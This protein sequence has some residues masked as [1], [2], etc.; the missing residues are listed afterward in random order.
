MFD[1]RDRAILDF[2]REWWQHPGAK[3]D[4]IRQ[5]FGLSPA[6]YYQVLG[7][8]MDSEAALAYDPMLIKRLQRVRDDRRSSRQKRV[9]PDSSEK[10]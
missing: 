6:R 8:L 7:K 9:N 5:T 3:E 10:N 4:A 2:E 1:E